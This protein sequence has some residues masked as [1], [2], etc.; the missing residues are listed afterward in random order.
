MIMFIVGSD[1]IYLNVLNTPTIVL[2]SQKSIEALLEKRS[3]MYSC[4]LPT[5]KYG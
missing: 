4:C 1:I 5:G 2:N 3:S